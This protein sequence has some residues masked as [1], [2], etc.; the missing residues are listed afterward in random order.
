MHVFPSVLY[1]LAKDKNCIKKID[2]L[3]QLRTFCIQIYY[4]V[5]TVETMANFV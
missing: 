3:S 1:I 2:I 5:R 4:R